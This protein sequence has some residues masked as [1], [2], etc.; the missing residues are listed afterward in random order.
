MNVSD[1]ELPKSARSGHPIFTSNGDLS[2]PLPVQ[3]SAPSHIPSLKERF[4]Y[5]P[6]SSEKTPQ[7]YQ[8]KRKSRNMPNEKD[9]FLKLRARSSPVLYE[10]SAGS[11]KASPPLEDVSVI[12]LISSPALPGAKVMKL[13]RQII[14][15]SSDEDEDE[16]EDHQPEP[17]R[18]MFERKAHTAATST[19]S[20]SLSHNQRAP[21]ISELGG[22]TSKSNGT[23]Q[24]SS[25][26]EPPTLPERTK[27]SF[28]LPDTTSQNPSTGLQ[29]PSETLQVSNTKHQDQPICGPL[30]DHRAYRLANTTLRIFHTLSNHDPGSFVPVKLRSCPTN[31]EL[32]ATAARAWDIPIDKVSAL[33][34]LF[35]SNEPQT[36]GDGGKGILRLKRAMDAP[37]ECFLEKVHTD[38]AWLGEGGG[39]LNISVM[40]EMEKTTV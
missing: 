39:K 8:G 15:V 19:Q 16:D 35:D 37:F 29:L 22:S 2:K 40:I 38:E 36:Q 23:T 27:A 14:E 31:D 13:K 32:F 3:T 25:L 10:V 33:H 30:S 20:S 34:M 7:E 6:P 1:I 26:N 5:V 28:S 18:T 11:K 12:P 21:L 17:K 4:G 9:A 24:E